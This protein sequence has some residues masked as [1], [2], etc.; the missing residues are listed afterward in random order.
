[1]C[2]KHENHERK[3]DEG[4]SPHLTQQSA[5]VDRWALQENKAYEKNSLPPTVFFFKAEKKHRLFGTYSKAYSSY[6]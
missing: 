1:M 5:Q 2:N 6:S 3:E 4:L